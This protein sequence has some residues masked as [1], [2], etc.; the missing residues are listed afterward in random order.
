MK[1]I[2]TYRTAKAFRTALEAK[3]KQKARTEALDYERLYKKIAFDRFLA[4]IFNTSPP[5]FDFEYFA[6]NF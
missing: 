6:I 5:A 4:R 1:T 2:K 3:L